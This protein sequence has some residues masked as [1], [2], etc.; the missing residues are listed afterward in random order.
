VVRLLD[1]LVVGETALRPPART[2]LSGLLDPD[3]W[4]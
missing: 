1:G 4:R 2:D 3:D